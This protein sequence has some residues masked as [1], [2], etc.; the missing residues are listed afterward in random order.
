MKNTKKGFVVSLVIAIIALLAMGGGVYVYQKKEKKVET[1][2]N[3]YTQSNEEINTAPL[4]NSMDVKSKAEILSGP[5]LN[6]N[7]S[8]SSDSNDAVKKIAANA[9]I[10]STMSFFKPIAD[11][12]FS[13]KNSYE[14]LC[15]NGV[16][17]IQAEEHLSEHI[18]LILKTQG[19]S[20]QSEAKISCVASKN[21]YAIE[22]L[23]N[24]MTTS[25][26][27][28][29]YCVSTNNNSSLGDKNYRIDPLTQKCKPQ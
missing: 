18:N 6:I 12:V 2:S 4:N 17:N 21:S 15:T 23:F 10:R 22:V 1:D 14:S 28:N 20:S 25:N 3:I 9:V 27:W 26:S 11:I 5:N 7:S 8:V 29:S 16:I 13:N 24:E 19:V